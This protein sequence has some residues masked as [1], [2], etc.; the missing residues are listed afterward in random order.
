MRL[1]V[2]VLKLMARIIRLLVR[3]LKL[4]AG[5]VRLLVRVLKLLARIVRLLVR[6]L[7]LLAQIIRL[8][9]RVLKLLARI[10]R[11]LARVLK[12]LARI[13]RLL[14]V[15][16]S[17][18]PLLNLPAG[19]QV[20][21]ASPSPAPGSKAGWRKDLGLGSSPAREGPDLRRKLS[22]QTLVKHPTSDFRLL[23]SSLSLLQP[24]QRLLNSLPS[25]FNLFH[26]VGK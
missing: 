6:V 7:K 20:L 13:V 15:I 21:S 5:I 25:F 14:A 19:R 22:C 3:V 24:R 4:L 23:T 8:L 16:L 18:R 17:V 1:L 26:T 10:V 12:L 9:V 2:R 11:L